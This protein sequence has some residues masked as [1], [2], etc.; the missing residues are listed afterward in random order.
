MK[1]R[2]NLQKNY[3]S[4]QLLAQHTFEGPS[5]YEGVLTGNSIY[6]DRHQVVKSF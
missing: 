3:L 5:K 2:D 6:L 1:P 4:L